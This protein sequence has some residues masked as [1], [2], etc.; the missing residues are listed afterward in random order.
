MEALSKLDVVESTEFSRGREEKLEKALAPVS[1]RAP[2]SGSCGSEVRQM[3]RPAPSRSVRTCSWRCLAWARQWTRAFS[4]CLRS[5]ASA[6]M[7]TLVTDILRA[8]LGLEVLGR[9]QA[10]CSAR[11]R[12]WKEK[13]EGTARGRRFTER[14]RTEREV[15]GRCRT[16]VPCCSLHV[17]LSTLCVL[18]TVGVGR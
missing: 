1:A 2:A 12:R 15:V 10:R 11:G 4:V 9:P 18:A 5:T 7:A 14:E 3:P 17:R 6:S 13:H 8:S 16:L